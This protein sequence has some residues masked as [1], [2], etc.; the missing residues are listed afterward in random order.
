MQVSKQCLRIYAKAVCLLEAHPQSP[1]N[2]IF[3]VKL[4]PHFVSADTSGITG[5]KKSGTAP[6][7]IW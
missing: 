6:N 5:N 7:L 2:D 1:W 4:R 3:D